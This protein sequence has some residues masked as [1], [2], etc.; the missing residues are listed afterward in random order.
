VEVTDLQFRFQVHFVIV[1]G[2][3]TVPGL[4]PILAHHD[5][6]RLNRGQAGENQIQEDERIRIKTAVEKK[7]GIEDD[8]ANQ[9]GR[10]TEDEFPAAPKFRDPIGKPF[11]KCQ[12]ALELPFDV[13]ANNFMLVQALEPLPDRARLALRVLPQGLP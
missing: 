11:P 13:A 6:W 7:H 10:K 4:R 9:N 2:A 1:L 3:Q 8:P 5:D 12:L